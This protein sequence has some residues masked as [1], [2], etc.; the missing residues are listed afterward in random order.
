M[1]LLDKV[2]GILFDEEEVEIDEQDTS[3]DLF[4]NEFLDF[5]KRFKKRMGGK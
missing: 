4:T 3:D 5:L 1:G 2:K